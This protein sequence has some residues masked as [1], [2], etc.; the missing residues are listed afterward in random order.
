M[1]ANLTSYFLYSKGKE[2]GRVYLKTYPDCFP[3]RYLLIV[4]IRKF[5]SFFSVKIS[6]DDTSDTTK[7]SLEN[8]ESS[9]TISELSEQG[10]LCF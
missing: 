4:L 6:S 7:H 9:K 8:D 2:I 1:T 10:L 5:I 3:T